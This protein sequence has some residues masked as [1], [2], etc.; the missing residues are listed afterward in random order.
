MLGEMPFGK[1]SFDASNEKPWTMQYDDISIK[2][3][4]IVGEMKDDGLLIF[5]HTISMLNNTRPELKDKEFKLNV[6][7]SEFKQVFDNSKEFRLWSPHVD[8]AFDNIFK[9]TDDPYTP[10][11]S[12][13]FS[14]M[15]YG[16]TAN[17]NDWRFIRIAGGINSQEK[18]YATFEPVQY[19]LAGLIPLISDMWLSIGYITNFSTHGISLS[20][21]TTL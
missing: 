10:G 6:V 4:T 2:V 15:S 13:G 18:F 20:I 21:S 11:A 3:K 17:D 19:N 5:Y 14:I 9:F 16:R 1:A 8:I 7:S 12:I